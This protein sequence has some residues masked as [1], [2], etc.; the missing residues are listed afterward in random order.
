MVPITN[1]LYGTTI[2][3]IST[4]WPV[5]ETAHSSFIERVAGF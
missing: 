5:A 2:Y 3:A 1:D 4:I